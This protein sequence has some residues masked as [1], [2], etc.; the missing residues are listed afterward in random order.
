MGC[1]T[2][3]AAFLARPARAGP[4]LVRVMMLL[5]NPS[6]KKSCI[7]YPL[8]VCPLELAGLS[9]VGISPQGLFVSEV[10]GGLSLPMTCLLDDHPQDIL[11]PH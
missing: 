8:L 10:I 7:R 4:S 2:N 11:L 3:N 6:I 9:Q 1:I 5:M